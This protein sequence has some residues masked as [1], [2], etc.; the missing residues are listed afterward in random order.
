M[1]PRSPQAALIASSVAL[2]RSL[3]WRLQ[4]GGHNGGFDVSDVSSTIS[5]Y[6]PYNEIETR[7]IRAYLMFLIEVLTLRASAIALPASVPSLFST[8]LQKSS[9]SPTR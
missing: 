4:K 9:G 3:Y 5:L 7:C 1:P 2:S 6:T 8:R